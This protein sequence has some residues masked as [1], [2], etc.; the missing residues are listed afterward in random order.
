[1]WIEYTYEV[2]CP[3]VAV[4]AKRGEGRTLSPSGGSVQ[5]MNVTATS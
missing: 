3:N 5:F 4:L 1:M 2:A